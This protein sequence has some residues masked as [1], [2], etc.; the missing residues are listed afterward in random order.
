M[1]KKTRK[2]LLLLIPVLMLALT[3]HYLTFIVRQYEDMAYET[4]RLHRI[5]ATSIFASNINR[6]VES[7]FTWE[8]HRDLYDTMIHWYVETMSIDDFIYITI[9]SPYVDYWNNLLTISRLDN[10]GSFDIFENVGNVD[11]IMD[12]ISKSN[13]GFIEII[14]NGEQVE[15]FFQAIP[16]YNTKYW[17]FVG[18]N[19]VRVVETFD[20]SVLQIPIIAIGLLFTI[21]T[22]DSVWQRIVKTKRK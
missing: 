6:L 7:G 14:I 12:A 16:L 15:L 18:V 1:N 17:I 9:V 8:E 21:S 4:I 10:I 22:M 13:T 11:I 20:F 5:E 3:L 2:T 19:R